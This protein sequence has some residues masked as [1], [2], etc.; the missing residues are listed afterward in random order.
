MLV[1]PKK[2]SREELAK[3]FKD[4]RTLKAFEQVFEILPNEINRQ[5]KSLDEIQFQ[6]E[7]AAA[8]SLLAIALIRAV[9]ALAEVKAMEPAH[10]CN[11]QHDELTPRFEHA[12]P[13]HIEPTQ[14]QYQEI[15]S[16]ELI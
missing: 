9:E 4:P 16:L 14:I 5:D 10:Q 3:I 15:N 11:C 6:V 1:R 12:T 2:P 8:Q 7:S 13:D